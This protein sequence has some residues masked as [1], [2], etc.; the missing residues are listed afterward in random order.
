MT[1]TKRIS[2]TIV[3][4]ALVAAAM[5]TVGCSN[6]ETVS[7]QPTVADMPIG[8]NVVV[9]NN[10]TTRS[11]ATTTTSDLTEFDVWAFRADADHDYVANGSYVMGI[12]ATRGYLFR[13]SSSIGVINDSIKAL[14]VWGYAN[15]HQVT[16]WPSDGTQY[17]S[18]YAVSPSSISGTVTNR[19]MNVTSTAPTFSYTADEAANGSHSDQRDLLF[20][21]TKVKLTTINKVGKDGQP[22][23]SVP[24]AF[25]H[26][27]SEVKFD[28][29]LVTGFPELKVVIKSIKICNV[30]HSGI[31]TIGTNNTASWATTGSKTL[32]YTVKTPGAGGNG[33]T[34]YTKTG[35][36]YDGT[37]TPVS[38]PVALSNG[39]TTGQNDD[40]LMIIP[41]TMTAWNPATTITANNG[42]DTP[43]T[44]L[45]IE[46]AIT[47]NNVNLL[48]ENHVYVPFAGTVTG[49]TDAWN[50]Q[51]EPGK[52]Y[53]YHLQFGLGYNSAGQSYGSAI[54]YTVSVSNDWTTPVEHTIGL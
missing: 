15:K 43:G 12:D 2:T 31:C 4:A 32:S 40:N 24:L 1:L 45:E 11:I 51:W 5:T 38:T 48:T 52:S 26:A 14:G 37:T 33:I 18:F 50:G 22:W 34:L 23:M 16:F 21:G 53:T 28:A 29:H 39:T 35:V 30:A 13:R 46:C 36:N 19:T 27:L 8:F 25:Q 44:Y 7:Q 49:S 10:A 54:Q 42:A 17:M 41:Q 9:D 3:V 20:A 47:Q 6:D